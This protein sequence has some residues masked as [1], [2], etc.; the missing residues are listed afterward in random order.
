[1]KKLL[2]YVLV[3][4]TLITPLAVTAKTRPEAKPEIVV[5]Y[6]LIQAYDNFGGYY[7]ELPGGVTYSN[8]ASPDDLD[9]ETRYQ[10]QITVNAKGVMNE[11]GLFTSG[12]IN[13]H[14]MGTGYYFPVPAIYMTQMVSVGSSRYDHGNS[15][16]PLPDGWAITVYVV[17]GWGNF[18][19]HM[20]NIV[21]HLNNDLKG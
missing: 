16:F 15:Q 9:Q 3:L 21:H 18:L 2:G 5:N 6:R 20:D 10:W 19:S 17:R 4:V 11:F 1:M 7:V 12:E 13:T 8:V 14:V